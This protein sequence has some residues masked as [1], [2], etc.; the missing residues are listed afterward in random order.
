MAD[1]DQLYFKHIHI[2][3]IYA[4]HFSSKFVL[5]PVTMHWT[6]S[7]N[8]IPDMVQTQFEM[9]TE[10]NKCTS[11]VIITNLQQFL[12]CMYGIYVDIVA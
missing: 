3:S 6:S 1:V 5:L 4:E 12:H 7:S 9:L 10:H 8:V 11:K 2:A